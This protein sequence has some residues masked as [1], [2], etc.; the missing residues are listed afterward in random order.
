ME[1]SAFESMDWQLTTLQGF[2]RPHK[3]ERAFLACNFSCLACR[4]ILRIDTK[5]KSTLHNYTCM[6]PQRCKLS[7][8]AGNLQVRTMWMPRLPARRSWSRT[9]AKQEAAPA[10]AGGR[11]GRSR[12][13]QR[14]IP[15]PATC[16]SLDRNSRKA[17]SQGAAKPSHQTFQWL[18]LHGSFDA[19]LVV[20]LRS[21]AE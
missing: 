10:S 3:L 2:F 6:K 4:N 8:C 9:L 13:C 17:Q 12:S 11:L 20:S 1:S 5:S 19:M 16:V 14:G 18:L 15:S 21:L 7:T